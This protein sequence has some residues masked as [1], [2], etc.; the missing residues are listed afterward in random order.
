MFDQNALKN[1]VALHVSQETTKETQLPGECV[2]IRRVVVVDCVVG[3]I[4]GVVVVVGV[5]LL[6]QTSKPSSHVC[7][8]FGSP[9]LPHLPNQDPPRL[10]HVRP[11][12]CGTHLE[13]SGEQS[14]FHV[15][16]ARLDGQCRKLE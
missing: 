14:A 12:G 11:R 7:S 9:G 2:V 4:V 3:L 6:P 15:V 10:Q 1:I 8:M 13:H 16:N 5:I